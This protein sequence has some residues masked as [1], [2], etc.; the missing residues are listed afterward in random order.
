[1]NGNLSFEADF[2]DG[3]VTVSGSGMWSAARAKAHFHDL[4]RTVLKIR[5]DH[6]AVRVLVDLREAS[7]QTADTAAVVHEWTTS[8]YRVADRVAVVCA[9]SLLALQMKRAA[10]IETLATFHEIA[11]AQKWVGSRKMR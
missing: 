4:E 6:G 5:R 3:F 2:A 7:V 9:T 8:I 10:N 11:P 1:M